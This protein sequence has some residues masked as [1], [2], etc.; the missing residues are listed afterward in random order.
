MVYNKTPISLLFNPTTAEIMAK[1][2]K[3]D[4]PNRELS[5]SEWVDALVKNS[6]TERKFLE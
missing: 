3:A 5:F 4:C 2:Y 1:Y 6:L